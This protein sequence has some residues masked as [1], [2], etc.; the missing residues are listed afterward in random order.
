MG[1]DLH[2]LIRLHKW[3]LDERRRELGELL[4]REQEIQKRIDA[5]DA[6]CEHE[7]EIARRDPV[8]GQAYGRYH[9]RY[10]AKRDALVQAMAQVQEEIE[11]ARDELAEAFREAKTL[12]LTQEA[13]ERRALAEAERRET[14]FLDEIGLTQHRRRGRRLG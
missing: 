5:L 1:R 7:R 11:A 9:E 4:G 14:L 6:E 3:H 13:R 8:V 12:E 2:A 10:A